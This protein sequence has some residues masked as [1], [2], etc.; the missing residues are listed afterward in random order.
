VRGVLANDDER[1]GWDRVAADLLVALRPPADRV[2][3]RI[4]AHRFLDRAR[5]ALQ[6]GHIVDGRRPPVEDRVELV[7]DKLLLGRVAAEEVERKG[8]RCGRGLVPGEQE[9][10]RLVA[11]LLDLHRGAAVRIAGAEQPREQIVA[12][13][14]GPL[15]VRDQLV[16]DRIDRCP[17]VCRGRPERWRGQRRCG[18]PEGV[19]AKHREGR[20]EDVAGLADVV[21]EDRPPDH[22]QRQ[23]DHLG[24]GIDYAT[25]V[26]RSPV[27]AS[28]DGGRLP[29]HQCRVARYLLAGEQ[30][31]NQPLPELALARE[32]P[33]AEGFRDLLVEAGAPRIALARAGQHG[34]HPV[35]VEHAVQVEPQAGGP[36][37]QAHDVAVLAHHPLVRVDPAPAQV[38]RRPEH[39]VRRWTRRR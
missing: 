34:L 9:D 12:V 21:A 27:P 1:A 19:P 13:G 24:V 39:R 38:E 10:Q 35:G 37:E 5:G 6:R 28:G 4:E 31:L 18:A 2:G 26:A 11:D 30:W 3:A 17:A 15:A 22:S 8:Q 14:S 23:L 33:P 7:V 16:D 32:Q 36:D 25:L 20:A 29:G